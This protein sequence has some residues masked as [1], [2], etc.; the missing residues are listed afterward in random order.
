MKGKRTK[1]GRKAR[2]RWRYESAAEAALTRWV[3]SPEMERRFWRNVEKRRIVDEKRRAEWDALVARSEALLT[4]YAG[5]LAPAQ[6]N[7]PGVTL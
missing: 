2:A 5:L 7:L 3:R 1:A 4:K 6:P